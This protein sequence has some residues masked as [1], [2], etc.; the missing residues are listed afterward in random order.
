MIV[1]YSRISDVSCKVPVAA[2]VAAAVKED[3]PIGAILEPVAS[4]VHSEAFRGKEV[5]AMAVEECGAVAPFRAKGNTR[6]IRWHLRREPNAAHS[7]KHQYEEQAS[8]F[9]NLY[10]IPISGTNAYCIPFL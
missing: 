9:P 2:D 8:H 1:A 7:I 5:I 6:N 3:F 4:V 10:F